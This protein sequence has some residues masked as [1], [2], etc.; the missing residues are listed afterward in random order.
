MFAFALLAKINPSVIDEQ[1][2]TLFVDYRFKIRNYISPLKIPKDIIIVEIDEKTL[3]EYGRWPLGRKI[4][5]ELIEKI[6]AGN[7]KTVVMDIIHPQSETHEADAALANVLHKHRDKLVVGLEFEVDEGKKFTGE[8]EDIL[9]NHIFYKYENREYL[10]DHSIEAFRVVLPPEPIASSAAFGHVNTLRD[11][12]SKL[13]WEILYV[14][15]GDEYFPSLALQ[16]ARMVNS[17]GP[18]RVGIVPL[19]GVDMDGLIIPTDEFGRLHINYYGKARTFPY[20]SASDVLSNRISGDMFNDKIVLIGG[21]AAATFDAYATPFAAGMPGVEKNATVVANIM[22]DSFIIKAPRYVDVLVVILIGMLG[23]MM[24]RRQRALQAFNVYL[25]LTLLVMIANQSLFSF[26]GIRVNYIYPIYT[27][28]SEGTFI[29][30]YRYFIE[31]KSARNVKRI[32]SSYVTETVVNELMRNPDM[33]RL[34]GERREITVL[35]SDIRNFTTFSEKHSPEEVVAM[36]NEYLAKMTDVIFRWKGTL[37]KF[38]GDEI[39]AFW[40]APLEQDNHAELALRCALNMEKALKELQGKWESEGKPV[41]NAGIGLNSGEV[42]VGNIGAEGKK[43]DYTV[44]GDHVNLGARVE[45]LTK[46]YNVRII[47]TEFTMQKVREYVESGK[48]SH[49]LIKGLENVVVKGKAKPV[50][51]YEVKPLESGEKSKIT[52]PEKQEIVHHK[53]K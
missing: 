11:R 33:A 14:K 47:I 28:L 22:Q 2:E 32:F 49:L 39:M 4:Q 51:I 10:K 45:G 25:L 8:I 46:K 21:T 19:T 40:G 52:E 5:A 3:D 16:A 41:L 20:I 48:L 24:S 50:S 36:L 34:G 42:I 31:E 23:L 18:E 30:S 7:P 6:F 53:E 26:Y 38:V 27:L 44:I 29:I 9:Y 17:I 35:F 15:Y 12:D 43:M 37:D 13:R 1:V